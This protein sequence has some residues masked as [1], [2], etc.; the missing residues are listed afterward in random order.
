MIKMLHDRKQN[1]YE[2]IWKR[3]RWVKTTFSDTVF[4]FSYLRKSLKIHCTNPVQAVF[5]LSSQKSLLDI[6]FICGIFVLTEKNLFAVY[7]Y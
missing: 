5:G 1:Q 7:K 6:Y 3:E 4:L 2:S